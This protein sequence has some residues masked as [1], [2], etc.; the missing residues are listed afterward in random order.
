MDRQAG[1][2]RIT[3]RSKEWDRSVGFLLDIAAQGTGQEKFS[4][5]ADLQ[6]MA[7][8]M[9]A[10]GQR[11]RERVLEAYGQDWKSRKD[12]AALLGMSASTVAKHTA[13]LLAD[14]KIEQKGKGRSTEYRQSSDHTV[15]SENTA[16]TIS[17]K[18]LYDNE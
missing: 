9:V 8:D 2:L 4:Y 16:R 5:S 11:N 15:R 14:G 6:D 18:G 10:M 7:G 1:K 13:A 17:D 3:G 12:A